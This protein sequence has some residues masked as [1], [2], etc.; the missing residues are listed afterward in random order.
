M[1]GEGGRSAHLTRLL[2]LI[3]LTTINVTLIGLNL[4]KH[5][6]LWFQSPSGDED[7]ARSEQAAGAQ[8]DDSVDAASPVAGDGDRPMAPDAGDPFQGRGGVPNGPPEPRTVLLRSDGTATITGS[9]PSGPVAAEITGVVVDRLGLQTSSVDE[10]LTWH[11][12]SP[13]QISGGAVTLDPP[14]LYGSG[15]VGVPPDATADLDFA[16]EVLGSRPQAFVV[17]TG[18]ID[19]LGDSDENLAVAAA[20]VSAVAGYLQSQ[21]LDRSRIVSAVAPISPDDPPNET[22]AERAFNRRVEVRLENLLGLQPASPPPTA[23]ASADVL[24]SI[25]SALVAGFDCVEPVRGDPLRI[26]YA[27]DLNPPGAFTDVPGSEAAK[28]LASLINCSGG[29][30]G[31][32]IEVAVFDL[33]GG[34]LAA[35]QAIDDLLAWQPA[36]VIGPGFAEPG[37]RVVQAMGG[38]VPVTFAGSTEPALADASAASFLVASDGGSLADAAARFAIDRGWRSAVTFTSPGPDYGFPPA[39]FAAELAAAGGAVLTEFEVPA[40]ASAAETEEVLVDAVTRLASSPV[41]DVILASVPTEHLAALRRQA[42]AAGIETNW[43]TTNPLVLAGVA[44]QDEADG[45]GGT[46]PGLVDPGSVDPG[47][48]AASAADLDGLYLLTPVPSTP[49]GRADRLDRS[50]E[51]ATGSGSTN[52]TAA[53]LAADAMTVIIEAYLRGGGGGADGDSDTIARALAA[54]LPVEAVGGRIH[55]TGSGNPSRAIHVEQLVAGEL[56]PITTFNP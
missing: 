28:H 19:D 20:R 29:V 25:D 16:S 24:W 17:V 31:R 43:M 1:T 40:R 39:A 22:D 56:Q 5:G 45:S 21:G 36:A 4:N 15:Q 55:Y 2:L 35:R 7:P 10:A 50:F 46:D 26:G 42:S 6:F 9:A 48:V 14:L 44:L 3:A 47:P 8:P 33:D 13:G 34:P 23:D 53:A 41:P 37:L 32:P 38:M 18:H 30:R 12:A 49:Q 52:P 51:A 54:G 11:P 27:A